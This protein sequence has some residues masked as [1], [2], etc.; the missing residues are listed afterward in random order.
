MRLLRIL[1]VLLFFVG[2]ARAAE[3]QPFELGVVPYLPTASLITHYQP[4]RTHLEKRLGRPV[5]LT[6][7]PDFP[8]F[9]G[10]CL[11]QEYDVIVL[12]SGL[13][14]FLQTEAGYRPLVVAKRNTKAIV[15]VD[16]QAPYASLKDLAGRRVA[17][18]DAAPGLTQ[19]G[20][21]AF[22][23]AGMLPGRDY[24]IQFV[25]SPSNA[26]HAVLQGETDAGVT[27]ANLVPQLSVE[28]SQ[29]LRI[30]AESQEFPGLMF[31]LRPG[32]GIGPAQM[33]DILLRFDETDSGRRFIQ[34][35]ALDGLR[36]PAER[37]LKALD[38]FLPEI[39][40]RFRD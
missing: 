11:R 27:T 12:G 8:T 26:L 7:A 23:K 10:R 4:L 19:F 22:R 33:Q 21:E 20:K 5:T 14:R 17:M 36:I 35:L 37:E 15:M 6:T 31:L 32:A 1:P 24:H 28:D 34:A 13:G 18:V 25:T 29:R 16:R 9:I 2:L 40:K 39:R 30:L 38:D 3:T